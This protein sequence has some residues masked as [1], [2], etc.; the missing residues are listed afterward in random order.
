MLWQALPG[1]SAPDIAAYSWDPGREDLRVCGSAL[2]MLSRRPKKR[3]LSILAWI[4]EAVNNRPE[5][6]A[7][8]CIPL[9]LQSFELRLYL[10]RR[11][12]RVWPATRH[13]QH[14]TIM[15]SQDT[16][17]QGSSLP[18]EW[19]AQILYGV[20]PPGEP[21]IP[22]RPIG[23]EHQSEL[24]S[25]FLQLDEHDRYLRFGYAISDAQIGIYVEGIQFARDEVFGVFNR[26]LE[27]IGVAHIALSCNP[28]QSCQAEFGVSVLAGGRGK[29]I[30]TRLFR[31]AAMFARNRGIDML[32]MQCL[33]Q[34]AAMMRI[35]RRA[36]MEVRVEGCETEAYLVVP[37]HGA[38]HQWDEWVENIT[39]QLDFAIKLGMHR[40]EPV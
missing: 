27:L 37:P 13:L 7:N 14:A 28:E 6:V 18:T 3:E 20:N 19:D 10:L 26:K 2:E 5:Y 39:G 31:R 22:I 29:G 40:P 9:G 11:S 12:K 36:G 34:N 17:P 24:L 4:G 15:T 30:G 16:H 21:L 38:F 8:D 35:A 23:L 1:K 32:T 25:H 33:T